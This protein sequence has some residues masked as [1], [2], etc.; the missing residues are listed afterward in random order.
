MTNWEQL[1]GDSDRVARTC[2]EYG[3]N[4]SQCVRFMYSGCKGCMFEGFSCDSLNRF[5]S[6]VEWLQEEASD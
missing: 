1:F 2:Q 3:D 4:L 5:E 6:S